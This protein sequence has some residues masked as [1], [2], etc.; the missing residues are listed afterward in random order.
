[1]SLVNIQ[2]LVQ[3]Q[4]A[5]EIAPG[6]IVIPDQRINLVPN[7]GIL[8]G[9]EALLVVDS[10]LGIGNAKRVL[11]KANEIAG[12]RRIFFTTTHFHPEHAFGAQAFKGHATFVVNRAQA[13]ELQEKGPSFRDLFKNFGPSVE[14]ALEGVEFAVPDQT[15]HGERTIDLGGKTVV[16]REFTGHTHSDQVIFLPEEKVLFTGDLV[17]NHFFPILDADSSVT[18]WIDTLTE[19]ALLSPRTVVPGHG[20]LGTVDLIHEV[21]DALVF[22]RGEV[23]RL[24]KEGKTLESID[25]EGARVVEDRYRGWANGELMIPMG[26]RSVYAE[27]TETPFTLEV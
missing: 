1:M 15:Y 3:P 9:T 26:I 13:D 18:R 20:D 19:L 27:L 6:V 23:D 10:G 24:V 11:A 12:S 21:Q 7:V 25:E 17:E 8:V 4:F 16:L 2:P 22:L 5:G 14:E